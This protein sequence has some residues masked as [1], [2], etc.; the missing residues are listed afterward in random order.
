MTGIAPFAEQ[1]LTPVN[2]DVGGVDRP[3]RGMVVHT[4]VGSYEGTIGWMH[5]PDAKVSS[6]FVVGQLGQIA[7]VVLTTNR[8]WTQAAGNGAWIGVENEGNSTTALTAAQIK[9]NGRILAWLHTT[10]G[11]PLQLTTDP[12]GGHGLGYHSMGG[13]AWSPAGHH[14]PG[15]IIVA[16]LGQIVAAARALVQPAPKPPLPKPVSH[17]QEIDVDLTITDTTVDVDG[18]GNGYF[19]LPG[20]SDPEFKAAEVIGLQD[21]QVHGYPAAVPRTYFTLHGQTSRVVI[22]GGLPNSRITIRA[23]H[24]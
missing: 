18:N 5:N 1:R 3:P 23:T 7:Q 4:A 14:C 9:A 6:Y 19:D 24:T 11:V 21:P 10:Y 2:H 15:P 20:V 17:T 22:V 13:A 8:A 12:T 16:Q